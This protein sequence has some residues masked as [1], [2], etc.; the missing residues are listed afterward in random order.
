MD[1]EKYYKFLDLEGLKVPE[2]EAHDRKISEAVFDHET[3]MS[4]YDL[5]RKGAFDTIKSI[6]STGKEASVFL[7][8]RQEEE[9][10]VKVYLQETSDFRHMSKYVRGDPRFQSWKNHRQLVY[11]WAQKEFKNLSRVEGKVPCPK[12]FGVLNNVLVMEFLGVD[13]VAA[14]R[15]KESD[16]VDPKSYYDQVVEYLK[17]MYRLRLVHADLSEYNILDWKGKP[18]VID[19]SAAVLLDH[20]SS[21][22]F[23]ERDIGNVVNFF[24]K[25]GVDADFSRVLKEVMDA[26]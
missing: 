2:Q 14:A 9:V 6:I 1:E 13:G 21:Q 5:S 11:M 24:R 12:P 26:H 25:L 7:G 17:S 8:Y 18:Y 3:L 22:E 19:F 23:L 4:L 16:I 20:P 15:L 10:A